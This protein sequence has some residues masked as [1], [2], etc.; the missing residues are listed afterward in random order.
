MEPAEKPPNSLP[1]YH[2]YHPEPT[3]FSADYAPTERTMVEAM[4]EEPTFDTEQRAR[5]GFSVWYIKN[6][7]SWSLVKLK[8]VG[9][10]RCCRCCR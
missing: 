4:V 1:S 5:K 3:M 9:D 2:E 10:G 7:P 6:S 8:A